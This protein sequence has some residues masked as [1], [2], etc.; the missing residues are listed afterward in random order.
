MDSLITLSSRR[1]TAGV[2]PELGGALT[3]FELA[4]DT[5][6]D[7]VRPAS[8]RGWAE[9]N[10]RLTSS[11]PLVPYSNRIGDGRFSFDG[12][13]YALRP[14]A[15]ISPHPLHGVGW[16]R[17][18]AVTSVGPGNVSL[19]FTHDSSGRDD[20]EWPWSFS[21]TQTIALDDAGLHLTLTVT[22]EDSGPMPAGIGIHPFFPKSPRME[23]QFEAE[24]VWLNDARMLPR[25]RASV[26]P[27]WHFA[28]RRPV[29]E[30]DVDNCF[31][32]WSHSAL[33]YWP[34][35]GWGLRLDA[36]EAFGHL[37]VYTT[38]ARASI[39]IEPV[40]HANNAVN[41][42]SARGDTGLAILAPGAALS[43]SFTIA[44][45]PLENTDDA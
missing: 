6:I 3:W 2:S 20:P 11:Y 42:A 26:P 19:V 37:V 16:S 25:E 36:S 17:A 10:V 41:L 22:N 35:R 14:N 40:S 15:N 44:P 24:A 12:V 9:R 34:E 18:W 13:D 27:E 7:F 33:L 5:G 43:G 29:A 38:P 45:F 1:F 21:A 30:L 32:G 4:N 39:A 23:L 8:A 31:A 28:I